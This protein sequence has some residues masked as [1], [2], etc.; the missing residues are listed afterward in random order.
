MWKS[1]NYHT[2]SSLLQRAKYL[3]LLCSVALIAANLF[4]L[5]ATRQHAFSYSEQQNQATWF[6]FQLTKEFAELNAITPFSADSIDNY[7]KTEL[8][9]ELTWSRFDLL[10]TSR[11]AD[12]FISLPGAETYFQN[13]FNQFK[14]LEPQLINVKSAKDAKLLGQEIET[15]FQSMID[16]VN[17]NFRVK[18]PLYELQ[19]KAAKDLSQF[20]FISL[21]LLVVCVALATYILHKESEF[22]K[23][24]SLT[25][26]LTGIANRLALFQELRSRTENKKPFCLLLLDLNS[27]KQINDR[28]GHQAGDRVLR[29]FAARIGVISP[30]C[31]RIGGDEFAIICNVTQTP[32]L[33]HLAHT[34]RTET[35]QA[36]RLAD[37]TELVIG[38]SIGRAVYPHDSKSIHELMLI[39]DSNMYLEKHAQRENVI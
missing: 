20:Q 14:T 10:L 3:L 9:Y 34:I 27:F 1:N 28:Y 29:A 31:Y 33:T 25:D 32:E 13:L 4:F 21:I 35:E 6:L 18:S 7:A 38:T 5:N 2:P 37:N 16:Y 12:T 24:Q 15:L 39:A 23:Q 30:H 19:M 17:T 8:K 22:H 11:E 26:S 36:I